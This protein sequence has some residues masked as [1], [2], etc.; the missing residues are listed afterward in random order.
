MIA[1]IGGGLIGACIAFE[2]RQAGKEVL[3]LDAERP[4]AAWRAGAGLLTPSGERLAGTPLE[5]DV[6]L[7]LG[8]WP[9][10]ARRIERASG[11]TVHFREG[12]YRVALTPA[13]AQELEAHPAGEWTRPPL[14]GVLAARVHREEGRVHPPSLRKAALRG[15]PMQRA[16]VRHLEP[17]GQGVRIHTDGEVLETRAAVLACGAWSAEFGLP[18]RAVQ[19]QALLLNAP[20]DTPALYSLPRTGFN[21]YALGRPD[22][23]YV[24][25]TSRETDRAT[26]DAHAAVWLR[27]GAQR[28]LGA[29]G[30]TAPTRQH[31]VGLRP[32][33]LGGSPLLG[34]HPAL[35]RVIVATGHG[36]HGVLLAPLS[37]YRVRHLVEE[38]LAERAAPRVGMAG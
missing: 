17:T 8:M 5:A 9:G 35:P 30:G 14:P 33:T 19:G 22:G 25:A 1:V 36:R 13:Q 18:V 16:H 11:Q 3:V 37:A 31:L 21:L 26:P 7:S 20:Q 28:L 6:R 34:P 29:E 32:V 2:L 4:G 24:G 15:L 10:F 23:V 12:V 27:G 38:V